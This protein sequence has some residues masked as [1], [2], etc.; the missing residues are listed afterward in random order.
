[1]VSLENVQDKGCLREGQSDNV[2]EIVS[3][4]EIEMEIFVEKGSGQ[5]EHFVANRIAK[6]VACNG[7]C[8]TEFG[9]FAGP[10]LHATVNLEG[11]VDAAVEQSVAVAEIAGVNDTPISEVLVVDDDGAQEKRA[12]VRITLEHSIEDFPDC[13]LVVG[14]EVVGEYGVVETDVELIRHQG[15]RVGPRALE[16]DLKL[17][18]LLVSIIEILEDWLRPLD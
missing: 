3:A 16:L 1:M 12:L 17:D 4:D 14:P 15:Y 10:L 8:A 6:R 5:T 9:D 7:F 2:R 11:I 18:V 13:F